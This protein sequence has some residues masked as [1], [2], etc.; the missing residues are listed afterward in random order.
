MIGSFI[1]PFIQFRFTVMTP[2]ELKKAHLSV[3]CTRGHNITLARF[4]EKLEKLELD[5]SVF[6]EVGKAVERERGGK[7]EERER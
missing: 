7:I 6:K 2:G 5:A 1:F 3:S 4:F